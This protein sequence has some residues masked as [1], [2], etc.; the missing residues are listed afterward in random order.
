MKMGG[1]NQFIHNFFSF[2]DILGEVYHFFSLIEV[3]A[4]FL[5]L[6]WIITNLAYLT[7]RA[8]AQI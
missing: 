3:F 4:K 8:F 1:E 7:E 6:L 5:L 2:V